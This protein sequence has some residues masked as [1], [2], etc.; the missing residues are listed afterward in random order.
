M[1]KK[2]L[3]EMKRQIIP[4]E[5]ISTFSSKARHETTYSE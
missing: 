2:P 1:G 4:G 3:K 5:S